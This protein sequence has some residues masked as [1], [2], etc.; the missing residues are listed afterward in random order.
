MFLLALKLWWVSWLEESE[1]Q[2]IGPSA[3]VKPR[4]EACVSSEQMHTI[5]AHNT[6]D[7]HFDTP[8]SLHLKSWNN[9]ALHIF[10]V[11]IEKQ[12][13]LKGHLTG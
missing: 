4:L 9:L 2:V 12:G 8:G 10:C 7:I 11:F 13:Q 5:T 1:N 6:S 3:S